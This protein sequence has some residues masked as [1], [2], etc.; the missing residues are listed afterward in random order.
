MASSPRIQWSRKFDEA[1][2]QARTAETDILLDF[3]AAPM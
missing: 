2:E 3:T 1:L